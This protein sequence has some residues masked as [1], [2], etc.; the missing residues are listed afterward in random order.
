MPLI[1]LRFSLSSASVTINFV[2]HVI[3]QNIQWTQ[4]FLPYLQVRRQFGYVKFHI[5]T[6]LFQIEKLLFACWVK[7]TG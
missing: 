2:N 6:R 7:K 5:T 4:I 1:V 3:K